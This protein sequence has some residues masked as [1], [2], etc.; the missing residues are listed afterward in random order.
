M[1]LNFDDYKKACIDHLQSRS[2]QDEPYYLKTDQIILDEIYEK[3]LS[4]LNEGLDNYTI[5][6]K[7]FGAIK[8]E[9]MTPG[10]FYNLLKVHKAH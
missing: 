1:I 5:A 9:K 4:L 3:I 2:V 8:P 7:G 6:R 10:K